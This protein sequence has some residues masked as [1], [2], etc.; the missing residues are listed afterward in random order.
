MYKVKRIKLINL[1]LIILPVIILL[2]ILPAMLKKNNVSALKNPIDN[3]DKLRQ[4]HE[5]IYVPIIMYHSVVNDSSRC[6]DYVITQAQ[7]EEDLSYIKSKGYTAVFVNDLIRYVNYG[8]QLP[9]K[10]IVIT[11][12]DGT[13]N[14]Y[15]LVMPILKKYNCKA[16]F[17]VVGKYC[18]E[19]SESAETPNVNYSYLRWKDI[20]QMRESGLAEICNHTY[21]MHGLNERKGSM[22]M[23]GESYEHYRH[24]FVTDITRTQNLLND[25]CGFKPNVFTYPYGMECDNAKRLVKNLS[26]SASMGVC[27]KPNYIIKG[28]P[29][30][31]F[32]LNRYN[33][34]SG[35]NTADFFSPII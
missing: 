13:Y 29:E 16:S 26:F 22:Q 6:N 5:G 34:P 1:I 25:A 14:G 17:S 23:N 27:E 7:F 3:A 35:I 4:A 21:D 2:I 30:C 10:P 33:R 8:E 24:A 28:D 32:D 9:D 31:L 20:K 12:D 19:A 11:F 18:E 15:E